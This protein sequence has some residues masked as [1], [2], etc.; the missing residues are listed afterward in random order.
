MQ[1]IKRIVKKIGAI[2][3]G[4]AFL[5]ATLMGAMAADLSTY[6]D[7]FVVNGAE[8]NAVIIHSSNGL[9]SAAAGYVLTGLSGAVTSTGGTVTN[10]EGG[11]KL[12]YSGNK[13]NLNDTAYD[14]NTKLSNTQLPVILKKGTYDDDEGTN[15]AET[16]YRQELQFTDRGSQSSEKSIWYIYD[17]NTED[18][19]KPMGDYIYLSKS[20]GAF[21]YVYDFNLDTPLTVANAADLQSTK[22]S[23]L[24][25]DFTISSVGFTTG[26]VTKLT[27]LAGDV[28]QTV[29]TGDTVNG[30]TLISVDT[31]GNSCTVEY[32]GETITINDGSTKTMT[33]G[34]II[35]VTKVT[36]A[37]AGFSDFCELN[38]GADKVE[39][40]N[41]KEVKVNGDK[42]TGSYVK[43]SG[44]NF[45]QFNVSYK[46]D[47][48]VYLKPGDE[49]EDPVFGAFKLIF[50]GIV[51]DSPEDVIFDA[52]G[53]KVDLTAT[54]K[55]GDTTTWTVAFANT[56]GNGDVMPGADI[57]EPFI[58]LE[59]D[60]VTNTS[61]AESEL[62]SMTGIRFL[63]SFDDR[64]HILK[65]TNINTLDNKTTFYD[66]TTETEYTEEWEGE[67]GN[68]QFTFM[69]NV[70]TVNF[71]R[72]S[73]RTADA[74]AT[75]GVPQHGGSNDVISFVD[76]NDK[77]PSYFLRNGGNVTFWAN[78][79]G[80]SSSVSTGSGGGGDFPGLLNSDP[81]WFSVTEIDSGVETNIPLNV[82]TVNLTYSSTNQE[83]NF[84]A[85]SSLSALVSGATSLK[86]SEKAD[87]TIKSGKTL[88]GTFIE[89]II[90]TG[91]GTDSI[92]MKMP[93]EATYAEVWISPMGASV[94]T[95]T[96]AAT[97][98][99]LMS[100]D[101]VTDVSMY[102][103][104]VVGGPAAN[105]IAADLLGLTYPA[106]AEASGLS[107]GEAILKMVDN[108][109]NVAL[110]AF[111]WEKDDTA[112]V[113]KV[114]QSYDAYSLTG[115]EASVTGTTANPTVVTA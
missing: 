31:N 95:S 66:E 105:K 20:S 36:P 2:S 68:M 16:E 91:A 4:A 89:K 19:N 72:G 53:E 107:E 47:S 99:D 87:T 109:A 94:T 83:I 71:S 3:T 112:R 103:A 70:F 93:D 6:P 34:T 75:T 114:L 45:D 44:T 58:A 51:E 37:K 61:M 100:E 90:P 69:S 56:T 1:K 79:S 60:F 113:A 18:N 27:L 111:G 21:V 50:G 104:I 30:V 102:N 33:D 96:E 54:N 73:Y 26:N 24:G 43:F 108:G 41:T 8:N 42:I 29:A 101:E 80:S 64:S 17:Q 32:G 23:L 25:R 5:G 46:P 35:G 82:V 7:P 14:I 59:G 11:Y 92:T 9:D 65:I 84:E 39:L 48:K 10:V 76:I 77:G 28:T 74:T 15:T 63:Y 62:S 22:L 49:F 98:I 88:Y 115:S 40:E 57:D 38:I 12:E 110:L 55:D 97:G 78:W 52:S 13:F 85:V 106:V 81:Y 86:Q 67:D